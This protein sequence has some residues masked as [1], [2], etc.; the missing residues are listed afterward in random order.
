MPLSFLAMRAAGGSSTNTSKPPQQHAAFEAAG[1]PAA[2]GGT[3]SVMAQRA[4]KARSGFVHRFI[5][6]WCVF[7]VAHRRAVFRPTNQLSPSASAVSLPGGV[8][9]DST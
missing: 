7:V 5:T 1:N 9:V 2:A 8:K 6:E 4:A 3:P